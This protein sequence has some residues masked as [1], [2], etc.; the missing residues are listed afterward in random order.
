M[1]EV[2][3]DIELVMDPCERSVCQE[4][5]GKHIELVGRA[6][7][8][9]QLSAPGYRLIF[10]KLTLRTSVQLHDDEVMVYEVPIAECLA[11]SRSPGGGQRW[12][13]GRAQ[14][15]S[16]YVPIVTR[17]VARR[18][19]ERRVALLGPPTVHRSA[20]EVDVQVKVRGDRARAETQVLDALSAMAAGLRD[21]PTTPSASRLEVALETNQRGA[22]HRKF[23]SPGAPVGLFLDQRLGGA[24]L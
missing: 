17:A 23:R 21:N 10:K 3:V 13:S 9:P 5:I 20:S 16:D 11:A 12:L 2:N 22:E 7:G 4:A 15:A 19:A 24:E 1:T 14:A 6:I 18:A 8:Q